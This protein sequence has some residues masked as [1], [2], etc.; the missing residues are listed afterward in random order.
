[1]IARLRA[2]VSSPWVSPWDAHINTFSPRVRPLN[3]RRRFLRHRWHFESPAKWWLSYNL[4]PVT[5]HWDVTT[6]KY[7]GRTDLEQYCLFCLGKCAPTCSRPSSVRSCTVSLDTISQSGWKDLGNRLCLSK[8]M[9]DV[10]ILAYFHSFLITPKSTH[11]RS[12]L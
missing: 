7:T 5:L 6:V 8:G 1:M 4:G 2:C 11:S 10:I 9:M 3:S 12:L